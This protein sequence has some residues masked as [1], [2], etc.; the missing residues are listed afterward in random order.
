VRVSGWT[1]E[2]FDDLG[3]GRLLGSR[4]DQCAGGPA[5]PTLLLRGST[6]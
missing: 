3:Y 2:S 4:R 6:D 5:L 1:F